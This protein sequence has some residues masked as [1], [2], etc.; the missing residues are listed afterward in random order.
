MRVITSITTPVAYLSEVPIDYFNSQGKNFLN[1]DTAVMSVVVTTRPIVG[2][3]KSYQPFGEGTYHH[4]LLESAGPNLVWWSERGITGN[5]T[6]WNPWDVFYD[7]S[8]GTIS[9]GNLYWADTFGKGPA[10]KTGNF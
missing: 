3:F 1:P 6:G 5:F 4:W 2:R 9:D 7:P 8:N 10:F